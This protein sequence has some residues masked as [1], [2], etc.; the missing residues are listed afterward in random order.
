MAK[1]PEAV[2][3]LPPLEQRAP[4]PVAVLKD[5]DTLLLKAFTPT[6]VLQTPI[7]VLS[8]ASQPRAE[9]VAVVHPKTIPATT[10]VALG[11]IGSAPQQI[12]KGSEE[13]A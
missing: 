7:V 4:N 9:L 2:L 6:A 11:T 10:G 3:L 12:P 1:V 13:Q 8:K 5:P